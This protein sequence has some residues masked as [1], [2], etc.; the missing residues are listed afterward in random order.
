M[1]SQVRV[2]KPSPLPK[3]AVFPHLTALS[4]L[5]IV[6]SE[7]RAAPALKVNSEC[8]EKTQTYHCAR[9]GCRLPIESLGKSIVKSFR[10]TVVGTMMIFSSR[11]E[12]VLF[13][14]HLKFQVLDNSN[15]RN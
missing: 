6:C 10:I 13:K 15:E 1:C 4:F 7:P 8:P 14:A 3:R 9:A 5:D 11:K 2:I 12:L